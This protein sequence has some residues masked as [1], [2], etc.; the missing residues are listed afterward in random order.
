MKQIEE[1]LEVEKVKNHRKNPNTKYTGIHYITHIN[2]EML[3]NSSFDYNKFPRVEIQYWN[4]EL[5]HLCLTGELSYS[6]YKN[7]NC[8]LIKKL[9]EENR[10]KNMGK[11]PICY[12]I[13][14]RKVRKLSPEETLYKVYPELREEKMEEIEER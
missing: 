6:K 9:L 3:K 5:E 11:L 10:E 1:I 14:G 12:E 4:K 7:K 8:E 2:K 13:Q